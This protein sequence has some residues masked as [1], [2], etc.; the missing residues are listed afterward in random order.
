MALG[1]P[2]IYPGLIGDCPD[3]G[4]HL[5]RKP[6][7]KGWTKT[8]ERVD[9]LP[10]QEQEINAYIAFREELWEPS[11]REISRRFMFSD[12]AM[13]DDRQV[14]QE[15]ISRMNKHKKETGNWFPGEKSMRRFKVYR[16]SPPEGYRES[17][18]ANA[19]DEVQFEGVVFS[20]GTVCVRWLT[21]LRS[22]SI[23]S[24]LGELEKVHGH[25]EYGSV[26]EWLDE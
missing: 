26:W 23:W 7:L 14:V 8:G 3:P 15:T 5:K 18:T 10:W 24:S 2:N 20:D 25:P 21:E 13:A 1:G 6:S 22:H 17:G 12:Q 9:L 16:K 19:P 4:A 11:A